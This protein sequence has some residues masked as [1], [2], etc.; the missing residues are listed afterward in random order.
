MGEVLDLAQP[1]RFIAVARGRTQDFPGR[2][3]V[4]GQRDEGEEDDERC[5]EASRNGRGPK[6]ERHEPTSCWRLSPEEGMNPERRAKE[7]RRGT[8]APKHRLSEP[9]D[10][11]REAG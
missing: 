10:E 3:P 8:E 6:E 5:L 9:R 11:G 4:Q 2:K 1:F 7:Q